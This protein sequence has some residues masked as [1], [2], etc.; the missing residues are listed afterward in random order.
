MRE[1]PDSGFVVEAVELQVLKH[2]DL[3]QLSYSGKTTS[4]SQLRDTTFRWLTLAQAI[5]RLV[6]KK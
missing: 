4:R 6:E 3:A 2:F 1:I 5:F